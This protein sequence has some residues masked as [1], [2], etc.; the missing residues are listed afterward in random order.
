MRT[1]LVALTVL[2]MGTGAA[3][4]EGNTGTAFVLWQQ[5][6]AVGLPPTPMNEQI[7]QAHTDEGHSRYVGMAPPRPVAGNPPKPTT[8]GRN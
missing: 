2:A 6:G 1:M 3:L 7:R 8:L 4:A 5:E